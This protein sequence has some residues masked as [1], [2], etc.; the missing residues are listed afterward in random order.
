MKIQRYHKVF[1]LNI[2]SSYLYTPL[3]GILIL[4]DLYC[5][6]DLSSAYEVII[7]VVCNQQVV[8]I[9][10]EIIYSF[11]GFLFFIF[12]DLPASLYKPAIVYCTELKE[13]S[14]WKGTD[15]YFFVFH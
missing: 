4:R 10:T 13:G 2:T 5:N 15:H 12:T 6:K 9:V 1:S 3:Q 14:C 7:T 8:L 11:K